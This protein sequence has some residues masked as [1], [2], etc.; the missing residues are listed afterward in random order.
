MD[1]R[2]RRLRVL[3]REPAG[4]NAGGIGMAALGR[5]DRVRRRLF[6]KLEFGSYAQS[7]FA[8][9]AKGDAFSRQL[10]RGRGKLLA[11][12]DQWL[13]FEDRDFVD[14][15]VKEYGRGRAQR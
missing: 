2:L 5:T 14:A 12:R 4:Q 9:L 8:S 13:K 10:A 7:R 11:L 1:K 3:G 15:P 6:T